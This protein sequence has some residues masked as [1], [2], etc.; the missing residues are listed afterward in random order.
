MKKNILFIISILFLFVACKESTTEPPAEV[1]NDK[2]YII[3]DGASFTYSLSITD[4]NNITFSGNRYM[5]F[6]GNIKI[7]TTNY[8]VQTDS[9]ETFIPFDTLSKSSTLYVRQSNQGFYSY[10][11]TTGYLGF[12]PDSLKQ[13]LKADIDAK[14]L[15]YPINVKPDSVPVYTL[16]LSQYI[17]GISVID[18]DEKVLSSEIVNLLVSNTSIHFDAFKIKYTFVIRTNSS[19]ETLYTAYGWVVKDLGFV[20]WEGDSEVFNF[21]F[22]EA[23]FPPSTTIN[24]TLKEYQL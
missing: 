9:F 10:A 1:I 5:S 24:M 11:D 6:A 3:K 19:D 17:F 16:S 22:N 13:F 18:V 4:T 15:A 20:K 12:L 8:K 14:W 21:L 23:I 7:D 2:Y